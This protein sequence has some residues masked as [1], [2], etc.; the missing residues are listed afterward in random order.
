M[1]SSSRVTHSKKGPSHLK[2]VENRYEKPSGMADNLENVKK[3][4]EIR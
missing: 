4:N 3:L 2:E 1:H